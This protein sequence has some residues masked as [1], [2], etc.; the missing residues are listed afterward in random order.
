MHTHTH[1]HTHTPHHL[2]VQ[3]YASH[4][5]DLKSHTDTN[6]HHIFFGV[7]QFVSHNLDLKLRTHRQ[8]QTHT[9]YLFGVQQFASHDLDLKPTSGLGGPL[10]G[11]SNIPR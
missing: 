4:N 7:Q 10:A 5:L 9:P 2:G 6:T 8:T 3:K 1:T 11:L